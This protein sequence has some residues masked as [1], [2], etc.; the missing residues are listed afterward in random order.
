MGKLTFL[1]SK[2]TNCV[3]VDEEKEYGR[4]YSSNDSSITAVAGA[5]T[6]ESSEVTVS[7]KFESTQANLEGGDN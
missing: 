3:D 4:N 1:I 2:M 6:E 7:E 5:V